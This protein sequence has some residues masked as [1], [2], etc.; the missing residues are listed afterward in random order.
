[1][2]HL[3]DTHGPGG[4]QDGVQQLGLL[5]SGHLQPEPQVL[6]METRRVSQ[7]QLLLLV[8][9]GT[10]HSS[11]TIPHHRHRQHSWTGSVKEVPTRPTKQPSGGT[12]LLDCCQRGLSSALG[13]M[14]LDKSKKFSLPPG[15][16]RGWWQGLPQGCFPAGVFQLH[17]PWDESACQILS[18]LPYWGKQK[19][20]NRLCPEL[21]PN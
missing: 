6:S 21:S 19:L 13:C 3:Q 8:E 11:E 4:P 20:R 15:A 14:A 1:M 18:T 9:P 17:G 5:T 10:L 7:L 16:G 2:A 12:K